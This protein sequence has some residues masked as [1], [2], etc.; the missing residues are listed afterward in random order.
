MMAAAVGGGLLLAA[1]AHANDTRQEWRFDGGSNPA[2][3]E[4]CDPPG[5]TARAT[6][7]TGQ[8]S[9]GWQSELPGLG[10]ATGFWDLGR[11]GSIVMPVSTG[12]ETGART[13]RVRVTQWVDGGI[14][15]VRAG[16]SV[17]GASFTS[18][19]RTTVE[20]GPLGGWEAVESQW[21]LS[22]GQTAGEVTITGAPNGSLVDSVVVAAE[23]PGAPVVLS[24]RRLS[25]DSDEVEL[26]WPAAVTGFALEGTASLSAPDWQP[27]P[28]TP[29]VVGDRQLVNTV[30]GG[31]AKFFRLRK[32]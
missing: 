29:Q 27:V 15:S 19:Q 5:V 3:P 10:T 25:P 11:S 31:P 20:S 26:S 32:P 21:S 1:M 12:T 8:F 9:S 22:E 18:E 2:A 24:I 16:V 14:F 17:A 7:T 6:V 23:A 13:V 4:V 30:A 28:G